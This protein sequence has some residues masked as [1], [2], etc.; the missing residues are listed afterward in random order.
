MKTDYNK[1]N[2][3]HENAKRNSFLETLYYFRILSID[4]AMVRWF[5]GSYSHFRNIL[6]RCEFELLPFQLI[7]PLVHFASVDAFFRSQFLRH[8]MSQSHSIS[9]H[10]CSFSFQ[11]RSVSFV[12]SIFIRHCFISHYRFIFQNQFSMCTKLQH[13]VFNALRVRTFNSTA[14]D[15][16]NFVV[17]QFSTYIIDTHQR[18]TILFSVDRL[19]YLAF[20][21]CGQ[22]PNSNITHNCVAMVWRWCGIG[23]CIVATTK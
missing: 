22:K 10:F 18:C 15:S 8:T 5:D 9:I 19:V 6:P 2:N 20:A 4:G 11:N 13:D 3:H 21:S 14:I 17:A 1:S 16:D 23:T 12:V 7:S